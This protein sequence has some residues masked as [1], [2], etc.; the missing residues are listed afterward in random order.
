MAALALLVGPWADEAAELAGWDIERFLAIARES[1]RAWRD[2]AV[3]YPPGSVV[4]FE[5][6]DRLSPVGSGGVVTAHRL[7]IVLG[8]IVDLLVSWLLLRRDRRA[9]LTYLLLGL[10]LVPMGL[11]RLDLVAT[12]PAVAAVLLV[13]SPAGPSG[14]ERSGVRIAAAGGLVAAGAMVKLWPALLIPALWSTWRERTAAAGIAAGAVATALWLVWA[15]AGLD[16]IRQV[17]DL[18]GATGWQLESVGGVATA[19]ADAVGVRPLGPAEGVRLELD[20]FRIG[21]LTPWVVTAGRALAVAAIAA[22]AWRG[23]RAT[24]RSGLPV[25]GAVMLGGV[26]ALIVTSPLLSPQFLLWLTP[27]AGLLMIDDHGPS[28][29]R[30]PSPVVLTAGATILTGVALTVFG[31]PDLAHPLAAAMLAVRNALL[32]MLPISCWRWLDRSAPPSGG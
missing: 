15:G 27:W 18:R 14:R 28:T 19:L 24:Q 4:V 11:L 6:L 5:L 12:L 9:G 31:P 16:P 13:F 8:L 26:A 10:P 20:A 3:E 30:P 21:T 1:G 17:V 7:L 25:A 32:V 29:R 23:R 22:L 2:T